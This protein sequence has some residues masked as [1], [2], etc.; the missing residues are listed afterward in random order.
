MICG[1][2]VAQVRTYTQ[3]LSVVASCIYRHLPIWHYHFRHTCTFIFMFGVMLSTN[4]TV[5][6]NPYNQ[7]LHVSVLQ[8]SQ[9][10]QWMVKTHIVFDYYVYWF[11]AH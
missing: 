9:N 1:M 7:Q 5:E 4:V 3:E 10:M 2:Q 6:Q 11:L 8:T